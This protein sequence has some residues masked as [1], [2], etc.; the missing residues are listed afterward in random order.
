MGDHRMNTIGVMH[1]VDTLSLGGTERVAMNLANFLPRDKYRAHLCTTRRDGP[2]AKLVNDDVGRLRLNRRRTFEMRAI[3]RLVSFIR[4]NRI[5]ILHAH[6]TSIV[7]ANIASMFPPYPKIV[8]HDHYGTNERKERSV[9]KFRRLTA[10]VRAVVAVSQPLADW[11]RQRLRFPAD[12]VWCLPNFI[13]CAARD[14]V[15]GG[16]EPEGLPGRKGKRIVC[17]ANLRAAK[18]H[19]T[20]LRAMKQIVVQHP[21][22]HL[23]LVGAL[24]NAGCHE[25]VKREIE[26]LALHRHVSLL[27]QREDVPAILRACDVGVLSS[28]SEGLP[29]S[30]LEYG[31]AGLAVVATRVGQ[32]PVV[33]DEGRAGLLVPPS[34]PEQLAD[35]IGS[36]LADAT[37][38]GELGNAF[39]SRVEDQFSPDAAIRQLCEIYDIVLENRSE[40]CP[41]VIPSC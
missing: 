7:S 2:L 8:W 5:A 34:S 25:S 23:L 11:S 27:G 20:L 37:T 12:R 22:A 9:W 26:A 39:R 17:V 31:T 10:R 30:L 3:R 18:D 15:S 40:S 35:S 38:R 13:D 36:I 32:C 28:T 29:M 4:H 24:D 33:L 19:L 16:G 1:L 21:E 41:K 14:D 6:G